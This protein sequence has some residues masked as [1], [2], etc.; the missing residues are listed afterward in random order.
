MW[1]NNKQ[2]TYLIHRLVAEAFIPN[3]NNYLEINHK[4]ENKQNNNV[5]NLEWCTRSYNINYGK[6]NNNICKAVMQ[7]DKKGKFIK[8]WKSIMEVQRNLGLNNSNI[9]QC[10]QNKSK[11]KSVGGY[12]WKYKEQ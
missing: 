4:D 7:Y 10:C 2:K 5:D 1:K 9:S 3:S 8:E 6:R 12:I 11:Y